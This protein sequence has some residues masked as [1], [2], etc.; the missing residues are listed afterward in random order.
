MRKRAVVKVKNAFEFQLLGFAGL[1]VE[2]RR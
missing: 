1:W 2:S